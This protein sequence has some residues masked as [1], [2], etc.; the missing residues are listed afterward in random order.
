MG[1][2]I[3]PECKR[4]NKRIEM[5][6]EPI[7]WPKKQDRFPGG[8]MLSKMFE[9]TRH[10]INWTCPSCDYQESERTSQ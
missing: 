1:N 6:S 3:C 8:A 4:H 7:K 9:L 5:N 2:T 10:T